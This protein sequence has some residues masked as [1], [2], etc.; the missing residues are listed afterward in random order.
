MLL[1]EPCSA[2][3]VACIYGCWD[4]TGDVGVTVRDFLTIIGEYGQIEPISNQC[5][6]D[7]AFGENDYIGMVDI[8]SWDWVLAEDV[9]SIQ[10]SVPL[11]G[12]G[13][14]VGDNDGIL[15][16]LSGLDAL[17][18]AGK[19]YDSS[20]QDFLT[21]RLYIH[22]DQAQ[23]EVTL[24]PVYDRMSGK[25]VQDT[26]GGLYE[27]NLKEGLVR[28]S[29]ANSVVPPGSDSIA[30]DPRYS[31]V[32]DV[33]IGLHQDE[34][35]EYFGR[36]ILDA[37]FDENG[38]VYVVPVVVAPADP[39]LVY[40]ASA[41]LELTSEETPPYNVVQL[42]DDPN[43]NRDL[44]GLREI[45]VDNEG[46]L[47]VVNAHQYNESDTLWIYN[48]NT[49]DMIE[50]V[51]LGDP[52]Q[53]PSI[54]NPIGL[55][56][57]N[58]TDRLYLSSGLNQPDANSTSVYALS[59]DTIAL[60]D[61]IT[62]SGMGHVTDIT[63]DSRT[64]T[65]WVIG[66]LMESI[67][68][69]INP[70]Q[71]PFYEPYLASIP[72]GETEVS[73][74]ALDDPNSNLALPM[75]ILWTQ[76]QQIYV[77]TS[78][79]GLNNGT[80]WQDAYNYL[81]DVLADPNFFGPAEIRVAQGTYKPDE[82]DF[83]SITPGDRTATFQL[84]NDVAIYGGFPTGGGVWGD[85]D[86]DEYETILSGDLNGDD[87]TIDDPCDLLGNEPSR[88]DNSYHVVTGSGTDPNAILDG[89]SITAG[90]ANSGYPNS[91][92]GG[93]F[94]DNG[95]PRVTHCKFYYN[96][97]FSAGGMYNSD[98]S[99][100]VTN[101]TFID[102]WAEFGSGI[103]N[104]GNSSPKV[105]GCTFTGNRASHSGAMCNWVGSIPTVRNCTF[106]GNWGK[107]VGAM[108]NYKGSVTLSN[109][110]LWSN[111]GSFGGNEIENNDP[112]GNPVISYCDIADCLSSGLWDTSLGIDGG[113]NIDADPLF[114]YANNPDPNSRDYHLLER[115]PC[116]DAGDPN[117][118]YAGQTDIDGEPR[119]NGWFVDIG[120]DE[121]VEIDYYVDNDAPS[122]PGPDD[123]CVSDPLEDGSPAHPFDSI[124][125]AI[126]IASN[127]NT[128]CVLEGTYTGSGNRDI[129][130]K[131]KAITVIGRSG[132]QDCI[133][134][135][136][137]SDIEN[138]RGFY[139]HNGEDEDS[140][141]NGFKII[142]GYH[143]Q[144]GGIYCSNSSPTIRNCIISNN[145]ADADG[146]GG[147]GI[148]CSSSSPTLE[149]CTIKDNSPDGIQ[150][151]ATSTL[152]IEG[153]V[154]IISNNLIGEG[155]I[156][157]QPNAN[158]NMDASEVFCNMTGTGTMEVDVDAEL[159]IDGEA[160]ID[161]SDPCDPNI[162]G[163]IDCD[164]FLT[165][166]DNAQISYA[167]INITRASFEDNVTVT[168]SQI[169]VDAN[170]PYGQVF[171]D[172]NAAIV[173]NDIYGNGDRY[174]EMDPNIFEGLFLNNRI[175]ITITEGVGQ[176]R[177]G[178]FELRGKDGLVSHSCEPNEF[179]CQVDPC[180]IPDCNLTTWTIERL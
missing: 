155:S 70:L 120:S 98:S 180:S 14:P 29:D 87:I 142:N 47:Y 149:D 171:A 95:S 74:D 109:C 83:V 82:A 108:H 45:E 26:N 140:I 139:F 97:A 24:E 106:S 104:Y 113:G 21:D 16:N 67:P 151:D 50:R 5:L 152:L 18:I 60:I 11:T 17:L 12:I 61:T 19:R 43:D 125:E 54:P 159:I 179:L 34:Y 32:A 173:N 81:Q 154:Y 69:T 93:M 130:L 73:A 117:L 136:Q 144:G 153:I 76:E 165:V 15:C 2:P 58:S 57:S 170:A 53:V 169:F 77:D 65:L 86:S 72:Y 129:D 122:D 88:A 103:F 160:I 105:T 25:L 27:I 51:M 133:I 35:D 134:N 41:K 118:D 38:Y 33:F 167:K 7:S 3:F 146:T 92:G 127:G 161:L 148:S 94:N 172:A 102:N 138:H 31:L 175:F 111:T 128:I 110:I 44:S 79:T 68:E 64:G 30:N 13:S 114:V 85:R 42:Y 39:N 80:S 48:T 49:G 62:I 156:Q 55:H 163:T 137:G 132:P 147:G 143:T 101:C 119:W 135:C 28:L 56:V 40:L 6:D 168:Y 89:F 164:G 59:K 22:D 90:H 96:L 178:L 116:I 36:P 9:S 84:I 91:Q 71:P 115:S 174:M 4:V 20:G 78:A 8:M 37:A 176:T 63:E 141:I 126:D 23:Y 145:I 124:Q 112:C 123:P 157:V 1:A 150:I 177:G 162:I 107:Y 10:C 166:K 46:N 158:I 121:G 75:S 66:F 131:G 52:N 100:I 99:P